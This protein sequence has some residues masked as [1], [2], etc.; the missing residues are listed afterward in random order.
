[1]TK[2]YYKV[3]TYYGADQFVQTVRTRQQQQPKGTTTMKQE[4][5]SNPNKM[6]Q[7]AHKKIGI[8]LTTV[9]SSIVGWLE[10]ED[11]DGQFWHPA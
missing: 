7:Q 1:M 6:Q 3:L 11:D 10:M 9:S 4:Q 5:Q 8:D 2:A